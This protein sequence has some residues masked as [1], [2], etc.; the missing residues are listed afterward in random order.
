M[1]RF[2]ILQLSSVEYVRLLSLRLPSSSFAPS[3]FFFFILFFYYCFFSSSLSTSISSNSSSTPSSN[4]LFFIFSLLP[5]LRI[6]LIFPFLFLLLPLL[7]FVSSTFFLLNGHYIYIVH[8]IM[9][10]SFQFGKLRVMC[11]TSKTCPKREN[12]VRREYGKWCSLNV[13][14]VRNINKKL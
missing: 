14:N 2:D 13:L 7:P 10:R 3:F 6:L 12:C 9:S 8:A 4:P 11:K 1:L 5:L